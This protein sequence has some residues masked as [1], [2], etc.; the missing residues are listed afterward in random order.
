MN[1]KLRTQLLAAALGFLGV[2]CATTSAVI[3]L[4]SG[5]TPVREVFR[6]RA[7]GGD[8]IDSLALWRGKD[9]APSMLF[10]TGKESHRLIVVDGESGA[11][12]RPLGSKGAGPLEFARPNGVAVVGDHL[13]V[14]ERGN[15]RVQVLS[16]PGCGHVGFFGSDDLVNPYGIDIVRAGD[17]PLRVFVTDDYE[18]G[19]AMPLPDR[20]IKEFEVRV[21]GGG[22]ESRLVR[23]FGDTT[24]DGALG[25]VESIL[26]DA[27]NNRLFVCDEESDDVKVY[28]LESGR[29][30]GQTIARG[31]LHGDPE[32]LAL[33]A[34]PSLPSGGWLILTEQRPSLTIFH[35]LSRDGRR[36]IG[37]LTGDPTLANTDGIALAAGSFGPFER[38]ALYAVHD[39]AS[40]AAY[41][42]ADVAKALEPAAGSGR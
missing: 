41:S 38:G 34:D 21:S 2:A 18:L 26:A 13:F 31:A 35:V 16:L 30:A 9:G 17:G 19:E 4:S 36:E 22:L 37:R 6:T 11:E 40:V 12:I 23:A 1:K 10:V 42:M 3:G 7:W 8:E 15:R 28:E 20:R 27:E 5:A 33:F 14:V 29:Y 39:D 24:P 25:S 32:G